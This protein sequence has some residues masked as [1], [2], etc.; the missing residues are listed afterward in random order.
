MSLKLKTN[1]LLNKIESEEQFEKGEKED[2]EFQE[3]RNKYI[4]KG[5]ISIIKD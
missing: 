2:I 1:Q 3:K 5:I 4:I